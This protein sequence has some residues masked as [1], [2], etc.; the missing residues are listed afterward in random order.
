[1]NTTVAIVWILVTVGGYAGNEVVYSPPMPTQEACQ[2]LKQA[3]QGI[4]STCV[5]Y[6]MSTVISK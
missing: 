5:Q 6:Q 2:S 3:V 1:M 4:R